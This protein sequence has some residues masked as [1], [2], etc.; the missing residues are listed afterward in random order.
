MLGFES[1]PYTAR[2]SANSPLP[3]LLKGRAPKVTTRSHQVYGAGKSTGEVAKDLE[4]KYHIVE[5]FWEMEEGNFVTMLEEVFAEDLEEIM[6]MQKLTKKTKGIS[7]AETD[8]IEEKFR[9]NLSQRKYDGQ[10]GIP[11]TASLRGVSHL[12][13]QPYSRRNP[14][15]ASFIDTGMYQR[16]FRAWV[17]DMED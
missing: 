4:T 7:V 12:R 3:S 14:P 1:F 8:K 15:R 9:Q 10:P 17:E 13:S 6:Q 5:L 11:T 16:S 2:Y